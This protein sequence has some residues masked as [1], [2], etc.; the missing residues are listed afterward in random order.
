MDRD[1]RTPKEQ[2]QPPNHPS[3]QR[4]VE[5]VSR[6]RNTREHA[7][8]SKKVKSIHDARTNRDHND[9]KTD[10]SHDTSDDYSQIGFEKTM[11]VHFDDL[12]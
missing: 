11:F 8:S 2:R 3:T 7:A 1:R 4:T 9:T 10:L 12:R 6:L 5:G